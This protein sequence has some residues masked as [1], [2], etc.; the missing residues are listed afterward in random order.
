MKI[1]IATFVGVLLLFVLL[2]GMSASAQDFG[3]V[4]LGFDYSYVRWHPN[5]SVVNAANLNGGGGSIAVF[6]NPYIGLVAD[7][8]GYGSTTQ[9]FRTN[10]GNFAA[11]GNMFTYMGGIELTDRREHFSP[12]GTLLFGGA[13]TNTYGNLAAAEGLVGATRDN[14]GFAM[15]V[16]G[17][18]D[19]RLGVVGLRLGEFDYLLTRLGNNIFGTSNQSSFRFQAGILF[20][21]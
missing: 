19:Y 15:A 2:F 9:H 20:N 3:G 1:R 10:L 18:L 8:Q 16:G 17:G 14:N 6:L 11:S 4:Q 13:H 7:L 12:F 21:F 5:R